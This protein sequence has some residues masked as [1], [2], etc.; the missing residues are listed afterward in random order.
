MCHQKNSSTRSQLLLYVDFS[1]FRCAVRTG[2][3]IVKRF[4]SGRC[5]DGACHEHN[6]AVGAGD[7]DYFAK[8]INHKDATTD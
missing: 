6:G 8:S 1:S 7:R 2:F 4:E 3:A 5:S